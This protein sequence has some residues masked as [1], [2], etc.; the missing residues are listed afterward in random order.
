LSFGGV[1]EVKRNCH[2]LFY[3]NFYPVIYASVHLNFT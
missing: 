1:L 3:L 2:G